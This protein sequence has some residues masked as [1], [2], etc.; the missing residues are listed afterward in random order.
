MITATN[1]LT[2]QMFIGVSFKRCFSVHEVILREVTLCVCRC[3]MAD[4]H[5]PGYCTKPLF[6]QPCT[7]GRF[8][9]FFFFSQSFSALMWCFC[10]GTKPT[11]ATRCFILNV[12]AQRESLS[13]CCWGQLKCFPLWSF[14]CTCDLIH[15]RRSD[16]CSNHRVF[17]NLDLG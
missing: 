5:A 14:P 6:S 1:N 8:T 3:S 9:F 16:V 12:C 4:P 17:L 15:P 10:T 13:V 7:D 2:D 11:V